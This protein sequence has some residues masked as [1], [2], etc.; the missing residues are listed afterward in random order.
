[1]LLNNDGAAAI[2]RVKEAYG[3]KFKNDLCRHVGLS[4]S[5]LA[6]WMSRNHF[7]ADLVIRCALDTG[8]RLE[9]LTTGR[10]R[11]REFLSSDT[12]TLPSCSLNDGQLKESGSITFDKLFLPSELRDPFVLRMNSD[13]Y[14]LEREFSDLSDGLWL[15]NIEGKFSVRELAF[16]PVKRVKVLGG[17]IPFDCG[18]DEI[19]IIAR[20]IITHRKQ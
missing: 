5:T 11:M 3:F 17:G 12:Q 2:E 10:G 15:V 20:V 9:W 19:S 16:V 7:P 1:M 14:F 18:I 4:S 8:V 6:T 13:F